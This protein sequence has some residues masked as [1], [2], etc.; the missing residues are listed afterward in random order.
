MKI[1]PEERKLLVAFASFSAESLGLPK[2]TRDDTLR[3]LVNKFQQTFDANAA[4]W[5]RYIAEALE[6]DRAVEVERRG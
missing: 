3:Y 4:R 2:A 5:R 6:M 1:T